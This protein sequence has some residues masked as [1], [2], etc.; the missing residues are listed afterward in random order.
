MCLDIVKT[1][2][3]GKSK[4]VRIGYKVLSMDPGPRFQCDAL[5]GD[6]DVPIRRWLIAEQI[7][8]ID[9]TS[10]FHICTSLKSAKKYQHYINGAIYR[11]EYRGIL[12]TGSQ[13]GS[14][15][16][17]AARMR[18]GKMIKGVLCDDVL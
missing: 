13:E 16:V 10:G 8:L 3:S 14:N 15:I 9:Y 5:Y 4:T 1:R 7:Y 12:A 6:Y 17:V 2:G 11:V 18:V